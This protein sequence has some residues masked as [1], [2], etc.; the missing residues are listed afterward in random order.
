MCVC[1]QVEALA[2]RCGE[3]VV[4]PPRMVDNYGLDCP[5]L[6]LA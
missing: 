2:N 6:L 4:D 3:L 5:W 1:K